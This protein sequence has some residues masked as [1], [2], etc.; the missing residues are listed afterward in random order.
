MIRNAEI[1]IY[2]TYCCTD[3]QKMVCVQMLFA[4]RTNTALY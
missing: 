4:A 1:F 2:G 3:R